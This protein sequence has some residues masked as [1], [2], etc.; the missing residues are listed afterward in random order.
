M[1]VRLN[2]VETWFCNGNAL[3]VSSCVGRAIPDVT[4][5]SVF[6]ERKRGVTQQFTLKVTEAIQRGK[7]KKKKKNR[8]KTQCPVQLVKQNLHGK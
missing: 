5:S 4:L 3:K 7:K 2:S 1:H 6:E 8:T